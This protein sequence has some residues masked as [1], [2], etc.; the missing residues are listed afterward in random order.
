MGMDVTLPQGALSALLRAAGRAVSG[1]AAQPVLAG[2]LLSADGEAGKLTACGFDLS[3][4]IRAESPASVAVAGSVVVPHRMASALVSALPEGLLVRLVDE[5]TG[6]LS[7]QAGEGRYSLAL[8]YE[9]ED[10]PTLPTVAGVEALALPFGAV[11]RALTAVTYAAANEEGKQILCGVEF[12]IK[13]KDLRVS[14]A[15]GNRM[16]FYDLPGI[17][18]TGEQSSFVVPSA[19]VKEVL[20]LGLADDD[21]LLVSHT[22]AFGLFDAGD[23]TII[24]NLL[25]GSYPQ[26]GG[27]VPKTC[28]NSITCN[29]K[30]LTAAVERAA[31]V[32]NAETGAIRF[33]FDAKAC[34]LSISAAND[35]G[36]TSDLVAA[37]N[38]SKGGPFTVALSSHYAMDALRHAETASV[39]IEFNDP[40]MVLISPVGSSLHCQTIATIQVKT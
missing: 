1:R 27:L 5:G 15:D 31:I 6:A 37:E 26:F 21:L 14:A 33:A 22:Q 28:A 9:A 39:A 4:G 2:L 19:A 10:F 20:K 13:G 11:K 8:A 23:V 36:S 35:T 3:L 18:E 17:T 32:A 7:V 29:R 38:G 34:D 12:A 30:D 25:A 24:T 16:A 40:R